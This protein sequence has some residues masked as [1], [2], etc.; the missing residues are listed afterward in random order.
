MDDFH[1]ALP[2][3]LAQINKADPH[4]GVSATGQTTLLVDPLNLARQRKGKFLLAGPKPERETCPYLERLGA[5]DKDPHLRDVGDLCVEESLLRHT[6]HSPLDRKSL[7]G[8][9][10][11]VLGVWARTATH[12]WPIA[13]RTMGVTFRPQSGTFCQRKLQK[14]DFLLRR[15]FPEGMNAPP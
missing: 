1:D 13:P 12:S 15:A 14:H 9:P 11:C 4:A 6:V 8:P 2:I 10:I 3:T 7:R 5:S